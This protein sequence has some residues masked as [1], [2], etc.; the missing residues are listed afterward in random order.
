MCKIL[1]SIFI[2]SAALAF[3]ADAAEPIEYR[4]DALFGVGNGDLAP[5]Y[6]SANRF[7][8]LTQTNNA[9]L[10]LGFNRDMDLSKRF[11]WSYGVE[12]ITG[13]TSSTEYTSRKYRKSL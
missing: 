2:G 9:Q 11:T 13:A 7:G 3:S 8:K 10:D 4:A 6:M 12:F 1:K 5:Y